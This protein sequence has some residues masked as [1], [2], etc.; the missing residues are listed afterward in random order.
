MP[1]DLKPIFRGKRTIALL[2][3]LL[4]AAD[5]AAAQPSP[6]AEAEPPVVSPEL[7]TNGDVMLRLRAAEAASVTVL[8]PGDLPGAPADGLALAKA[9]DGVWQITLPKP[10]SGAYRYRF[11][12]DGCAD[13]RPEQSGDEPIERH[14]M[15]PFLCAR[16][17][18]HGRSGRTARRGGS[19]ALQLERTRPDPSH[20][21]V[22]ATGLRTRQ[23]LLPGVLPVARRVR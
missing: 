21:G 17:C 22:Y 12:V 14:G 2:A 23:R 6:D 9:K 7:A 19:G 8:F 5:R 4:F 3:S 15:E 1:M 10:D 16:G 13:E 20:A 11:M 18:L